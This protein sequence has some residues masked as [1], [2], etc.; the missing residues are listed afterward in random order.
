MHGSAG[1]A[2]SLPEESTFALIGFEQVERG[3]CRDSQNEAGEAA[4]GAEIYGSGRRPQQG[5]QLE[6]V[7]DVPIPKLRFV[8]ASDKI[9]RAVPAKQ[10]LG[11][12][13]Q[14]VERS[15]VER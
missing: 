1:Y 7:D 11:K 2:R 13:I 15:V 12:R 10:Q 14:G 9:D 8:P 5:Y 6:G 3:A 4:T